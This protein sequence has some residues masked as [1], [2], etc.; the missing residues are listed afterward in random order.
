MQ[1]VVVSHPL[2]DSRV[3]ILFSLRCS[4]GSCLPCFTP[5]PPPAE[6]AATSEILSASAALASSPALLPR[7]P[8]GGLRI[9]SVSPVPGQVAPH[10]VVAKAKGGLK[11]KSVAMER[12]FD[13]FEG[14]PPSRP[15]QRSLRIGDSGLQVKPPPAKLLTNS[16]WSV[17]C[18]NQSLP[19]KRR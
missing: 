11:A 4:M 10:L 13:L 2:G 3:V 9:K 16:K 19:P 14:G 17:Y 8:P 12:E 6:I 7:P 5:S 1:G 18:E 15:P